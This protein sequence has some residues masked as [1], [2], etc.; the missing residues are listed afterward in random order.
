MTLK[1]R[2][3]FYILLLHGI[4]MILCYV[5]LYQLMEDQKYLMLGVEAILALSLYLAWRLIRAF[6]R[7]IDRIRQGTDAILDKEFY[8]QLPEGKGKEM[9]QLANAYNGMMQSIRDERVQL[10]EQHFFLEKLIEASPS[11]VIL[12]DYDDFITDI[13]PA[14]KRLLELNDDHLQKN[15]HSIEHPLIEEVSE[16]SLYQRR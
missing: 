13:N 10:Q 3:W 1:L 14:A 12:L 16:V 8:H 4:I 6:Q 5:L 2:F 11:G 7:P 9:Q 15:F